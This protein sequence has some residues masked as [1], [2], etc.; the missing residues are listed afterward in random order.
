MSNSADRQSVLR[1]TKI[2]ATLGPASDSLIDEL[3][4]AGVEGVDVFRLNFSY[5]THQDHAAR[6]GKIRSAARES[7]RFVAIL[8]DLQGPKIRI[9]GFGPEQ[10]F[11]LEAGSLFSIDPSLPPD[12]GNRRQVFT[13]FA[14]LAEQVSPGDT[15]ILGDELVELAVIDVSGARVNCEVLAG[16]DFANLAEQ[17]SPG[18]TLILGD[19]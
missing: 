17:V 15:L 1:S 12:A 9:G 8:A 2:V 16:G 10:S 5:G 11:E 6:I 7:G 4:A 13:D 19:D 18:D 14:N 3:I